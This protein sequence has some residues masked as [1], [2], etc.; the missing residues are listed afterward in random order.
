MFK[1]KLIIEHTKSECSSEVRMIFYALDKFIDSMEGG[2]EEYLPELTTI[3]LDIV[4][5]EQ[6]CVE[7][8]DK[9]ITIMCSVGMFIFGSYWFKIY[10]FKV[11]IYMINI[12]K[13][14]VYPVPTEFWVKTRLMIFII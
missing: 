10:E 13:V 8:K 3:V 1:A 5:N 7:L 6:C 14:P 11:V 12:V 9:A 2:I 4:R